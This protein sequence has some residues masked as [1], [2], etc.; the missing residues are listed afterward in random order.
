MFACA[1]LGLWHLL[2]DTAKS[3]SLHLC[4]MDVCAC[5]YVYA[6]V[7]VSAIFFLWGEGLSTF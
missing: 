6:Q 4:C 3:A 7:R 1:C 5:G 2:Y